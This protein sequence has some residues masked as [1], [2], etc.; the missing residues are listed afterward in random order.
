MTPTKRV[1]VLPFGHLD[2]VAKALVKKCGEAL[3]KQYLPLSKEE[4]IEAFINPDHVVKLTEV[5]DLIGSADTASRY[6]E[7]NTDVT[8]AGQRMRATLQFMASPGLMV[9]KYIEHSINH[10]TEAGQRV[11][12]WAQERRRLGM[13]LGDALDAMRRLNDMCGN[14]RALTL[15]FPAL[16]TIMVRSSEATNQEYIDKDPV[17]RM[18]R[19]IDQ[20]KSIGELPRLPREVVERIRQSSALVSAIL[21]TE[22]AATPTAPKG[23]VAILRGTKYDLG[24]G[25]TLYMRPHIILDGPNTRSFV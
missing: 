15:M 2:Q 16:S 19:R 4:F 22:D 18:G 21:M 23:T 25:P 3:D 9:P 20:G 17:V 12:A 13:M 5:A 1:G 6:T 7:I 10:G 11:V 24:V 8:D 14:G